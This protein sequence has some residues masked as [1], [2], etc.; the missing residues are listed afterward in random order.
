[1]VYEALNIFFGHF[2][3]VCRSKQ[4]PVFYF[5]NCRIF[6]LRL[7]FFKNSNA[8]LSGSELVAMEKREKQKQNDLD[9]WMKTQNLN[10]L[11]C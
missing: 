8:I 7:P 2:A 6:D 11:E 4:M 9:I 1:M 10:I 3:K 5:I